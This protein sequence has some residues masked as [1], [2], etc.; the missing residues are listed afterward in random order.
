MRRISTGVKPSVLLLFC[1]A[2]Y[3]AAGTLEQDAALS[4]LQKIA[5]AARQLNYQ[6][7]FVY[8]HGDQVETSRITHYVDRTGEY[9]KLETL[10]GPKREIIRSN[11][12]ILS[13]DAEHRVVRREKRA[14]LKA[15]PALLPEQLGSLT[16]FY[17]LHKGEHER[18]A[19][20]DAL[21]LALEPRD[22]FR[23][24]HKLWADATTGLLLKARMLDERNRVVE[25]FMFTQ[26]I[27]GDGVTRD[28]VRPSINPNSPEWRRE[29]VDRGATTLVDTGWIV[30]DQPAGFRKVLE[31]KRFK[32][33]SQVP[34]V[35]LVFCDGLAAV[36]VFIEPLK[37]AK[38]F[39]AGL[40]HQGAVNI[41]THAVSDQLVTVLG[42][43]PPVTVMQM[44]NSVSLNGQ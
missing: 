15:F 37:A 3:A 22:Q 43:V 4:W 34:V 19:G 18:I 23:Y 40:A 24:G 6:G 9:E 36:S 21:A 2:G 1:W 32:A 12:E 44:A 16:G 33:D 42:E 26:L 39:Q 17:S 10:D 20:F 25:Q 14:P 35:H 38:E 27:I 29:P 11:T 8:Q 13:F 28:S 41:Y 30:K 7:T 31:L 5:N